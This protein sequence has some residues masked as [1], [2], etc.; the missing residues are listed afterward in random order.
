MN[1]IITIHVSIELKF[2]F[3]LKHQFKRKTS[4][5][6]TDISIETMIPFFYFL[7]FAIMQFLCLLK[8]SLI[9]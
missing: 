9:L 2:N 7:L 1:R 8:P 5:L 3:S 6:H 4:K